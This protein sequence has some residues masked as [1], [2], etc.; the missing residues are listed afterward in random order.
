MRLS[1]NIHGHLVASLA[2]VAHGQRTVWRILT[3]L[4]VLTVGALYGCLDAETSVTSKYDAARDELRILVVWSQIRSGGLG[5]DVPD[6]SAYLEGLYR[7]RGHM[8]PEIGLP[9]CEDLRAFVPIELFG[10]SAWLKL[11]PDEG[12]GISLGSRSHLLDR[13]TPTR[14]QAGARI[15]PGEA[16]L[17]SDGTLSCY[18][19]VT[20]PGAVLDASLAAG[21][22]R[23]KSIAG[24]GLQVLVAGEMADRRQ[25]GTTLTFEQLRQ[26]FVA[27]ITAA[28]GNTS[29]DAKKVLAQLGTRP[30][31]FLSPETL[32][33]YQGRLADQ[34]RARREKGEFVLQ[35]SMADGD[36]RA[37]SESIRLLRQDL[38]EA[39]RR[40]TSRNAVDDVDY[41]LGTL[42]TEIVKGGLEVRLDIAGVLTAMRP[43]R[44]TQLDD[45]AVQSAKAMAATMA[46]RLHAR[47]D[48]TGAELLRSFSA[49]TLPAAPAGANVQPGDGLAA[50]GI[51]PPF[52]GE[53]KSGLDIKPAGD[54]DEELFHV[55]LLEKWYA[56]W[57]EGKDPVELTKSLA[58]VRL[59]AERYA[60][61]ARE[62]RLDP[63]V[64][65]LYQDYIGMVD[66]FSGF[67]VQV[68]R[69][70]KGAL[71]QATRDAQD[72]AGT[73]L[74][75][76][77][78][79]SATLSQQGAA[80]GDAALAGAITSILSAVVDSYQK[81]Q[82][83]DTSRDEAIK[84]AQRDTQA[85]FDATIARAQAK[86]MVLAE[87]KHWKRGEES[88]DPATCLQPK[89]ASQ[90]LTSKPRDV[91]NAINALVRS[92]ALPEDYPAF[93]LRT[94]EL[95]PEG[96]LYDPY[97]A[98]IA[99][100]AALTMLRIAGVAPGA[101]PLTPLESWQASRHPDA[102][103]YAVTF[104]RTAVDFGRADA[105]NSQLLEKA[106]K[107]LPS[108]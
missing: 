97:R 43:G 91:S 25:G 74:T 55:G 34:I 10:Q 40:Q 64:A 92:Q 17:E 93:V 84:T 104:A 73:A 99:R 86:V 89:T 52:R 87:R 72:T 103:R 2:H 15:L 82:Q 95:V 102:V 18:Q 32:K 26:A 69:I 51:L 4:A 41:L 108:K 60:A 58:L 81:D 14:M 16:F 50:C 27:R 9:D 57:P 53:L 7:N 79:A 45:K 98:A 105:A 12:C 77:I 76:G 20:V 11:G 49:G 90:A 85:W 37:M 62:K 78:G 68:K 80:D 70:E 56:E 106:L 63:A 5:T 65:E 59:R 35:I 13:E 46:D 44:H 31:A 71:D 47:R 24:P 6:D 23:L 33:M 39:H 8:V 30:L 101:T 48:L 83:R 42:R 94:L 61:Y 107:A 100:E 38:K 21:L 29:E 54:A 36:A 19:Q 75:R 67:L 3:C 28:G 96:R 22:D 66:R 1:P 88:F